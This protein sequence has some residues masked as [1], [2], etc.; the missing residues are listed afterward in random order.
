M[1]TYMLIWGAIETKSIKTPA[2]LSTTK[3]NHYSSTSPPPK[4][5]QKKINLR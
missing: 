5:Q 1:Y 4:E 2:P 3:P